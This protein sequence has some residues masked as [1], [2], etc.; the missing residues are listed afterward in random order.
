MKPETKCSPHNIS[1]FKA[2][3][4]NFINLKICSHVLRLWK[5][6]MV[7]EALWP[8]KHREGWTTSPCFPPC[9]SPEPWGKEDF[10][11]PEKKGSPVEDQARNS[12]LSWV[13]S[14]LKNP[15]WCKIGLLTAC[16]L[17]VLLPLKKSGTV[18]EYDLSERCQ[19][20]Q[21]VLAHQ[22]VVFKP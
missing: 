11:S 17:E 4:I 16:S 21:V 14:I 15:F 22:L 7:Q 12:L 3:F 8:A 13:W 2:Q 5:A 19:S 6:L 9:R 20:P 10:R 1:F 18:G